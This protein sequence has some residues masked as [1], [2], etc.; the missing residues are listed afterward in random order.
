MTTD[1]DEENR[2][3]RE[4]L[5]E[6][7]PEPERGRRSSRSFGD[8]FPWFARLFALLIGVIDGTIILLLKRGVDLVEARGPGHFELFNVQH[9]FQVLRNPFILTALFLAILSIIGMT[10]SFSHDRSHRLFSIIG[11]ASYLTIVTG[12]ALFI[13][14]IVP[15]WV[16]VGLI[17]ILVSLFITNI[18]HMILWFKDKVKYLRTIRQ[19]G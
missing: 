7:V 17:I 9:W 5:L 1:T 13:N 18:Y 11:G 16:I 12:S 15:P 4:E 10:V 14:E 3:G 19:G 8:Y 6:A 2:G